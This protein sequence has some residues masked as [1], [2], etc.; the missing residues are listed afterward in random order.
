MIKK[1]FPSKKERHKL[2]GSVLPIEGN[3]PTTKENMTDIQNNVNDFLFEIESVGVSNVKHPVT[4]HSK[5]RPFIQN[6]VGTFQLTTNLKQMNK[7]INMSRLTEQLQE[8]YEKDGFVMSF[9]RL[10]SFTKELSERMEQDRSEIKVQYPWFFERKSPSS[11][12][13]GLSHANVYMSVIYERDHAF[14]TEVGLTVAVTTLCPCSKEI[15]EYSA[16]NQRGYITITAQLSSP[17]QIEQDWKIILLEAA[18]SNASSILY[19]ILKRPDEK[20]VTE[21]AYENPRFVED[22]VRL[23]AADLYEKEY[24]KTF[25]VECRNEESIHM[26]DAIAKITYSKQ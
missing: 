3:K 5:Y 21:H 1:I 15:S 14:S 12:K 20:F 25:T 18:E 24:I 23:V 11:K 10:Y 22:V 9:D 7:G 4:V 13:A 19:P 2:F 17:L 8:Y 6:T 26:H 16:H